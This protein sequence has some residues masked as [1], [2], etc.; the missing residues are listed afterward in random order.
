MTPETQKY[1]DNFFELFA[2]DGWKQLTEELKENAIN[3]NNASAI[4]TLEDLHFRKGQL[5]MLGSIVNLPETLEATL[6]DQQENTDVE[7]L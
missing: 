2:S 4:S 7:G 6:R 5:N 1:Y 3:I